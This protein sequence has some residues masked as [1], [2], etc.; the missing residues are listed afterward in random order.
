ME[1]LCEAE[2]WG[3]TPHDMAAIAA[4]NL[5]MYQEA[6]NHAKDALELSPP[7]EKERLVK[8]LLFCEAKI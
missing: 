2:A 3:Y 5:G 4:Y 7:E 8:N 1:Y 6:V